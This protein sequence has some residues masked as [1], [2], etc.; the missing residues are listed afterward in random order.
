VT[1]VFVPA[2]HTVWFQDPPAVD[3]PLY[4]MPPVAMFAT[5]IAAVPLGIARHAIDEFVTLAD[6]KTPLRS[7]TVLADQPVVQDRLGRA[8][9]LV[10][11]GRRHLSGTLDDLWGACR[12]DTYR[13]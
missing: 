10:A 13:P 3:R 8:V 7:T 12:P 4:R 11:A 1:D 9:A 5:F 6:S 2:S